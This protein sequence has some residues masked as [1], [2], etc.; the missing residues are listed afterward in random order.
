MRRAS[1]TVSNDSTASTAGPDEGAA[2]DA[3]HAAGRRR[4][5]TALG[6]LAAGVLVV[7]QVTKIVAVSRLTTGEYVPLLG[8]VFGLM[9]VFNPGAAFSLASGSTWI[10]TIVA[11]V[12]AVVIVRV[13]RRIG[14]RGWAVALG[15]LLGGNLGNL[16]DRLFREPGFGV[17]HVVDFLNYGGFFVGN[18]ADI[19]IVLAAGGMAVLAFL[20]IGIDGTRHAAT[21]EQ[22]SEPGDVDE[23]DDTEAGDGGERPDV[24]ETVADGGMA[25]A[26][27]L[28]GR[29]TTDV[30]GD[31]AGRG[32]D[33]SRPSSST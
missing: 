33:A 27:T 8:E 9:L 7:D 23:A 19:A 6:L 18:V 32:P 16:G 1:S 22:S 31:E 5:L 25:D 11:V 14:S 20:G 24:V 21:D 17:G 10:F 3:E 4:L 26:E 30:D 2:G 12:V 29:D 13:S 15:A 28:P